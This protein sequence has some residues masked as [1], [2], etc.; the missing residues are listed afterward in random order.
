MDGDDLIVV[1]DFEAVTLAPG[2]ERN[3]VCVSWKLDNDE[4]FYV[5][6]IEMDAGPGWHHSNWFVVREGTLDFEESEGIEAC[7]QHFAES[8]ALGIAGRLL[9]GQSTQARHEVERF[10]AGAGILVPAHALIV[11]DVHLVNTSDAAVTTSIALTL[12]KLRDDDVKHDLMAMGLA[13]QD[14]EVP[15]GATTEVVGECDLEA[16]HQRNYSRPLDWSIHYI[17]PHYHARGVSAKLEVIGGP[18]DGLDLLAGS[19]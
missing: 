13:Y 10:P 12:T 15:G 18:H 7:S 14:L 11:G 1:H 17:L 3:N 5:N 19:P 4:P 2:E 8:L 16:V 9:F 6:A